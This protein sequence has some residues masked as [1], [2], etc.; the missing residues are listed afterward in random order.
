MEFALELIIKFTPRFGMKSDPIL[1]WA[2][3]RSVR[4]QFNGEYGCLFLMSSYRLN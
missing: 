3:F 1:V 2:N 4:S